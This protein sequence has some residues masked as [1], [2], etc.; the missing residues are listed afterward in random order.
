MLH[1]LA[2]TAAARG[3]PEKAVMLSGAARSLEGEF[4][5]GIG[6]DVL[7]LTQ[8]AH[9]TW[10]QLPPAQ[11]QRAWNSGQDMDRQ[12]AIKAALADG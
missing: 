6:V 2:A 10:E 11:A 4:G 9:T 5:G 1:E 7:Q 12:Q 8:L 3:Q